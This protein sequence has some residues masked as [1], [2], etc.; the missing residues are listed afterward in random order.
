MGTRE[1]EPMLDMFLHEAFQ[2]VTQLELTLLETEQSG[3]LSNEQVNLIFRIMHTMKG[4]SS[5]MQYT[6][7]MELTHHAEDLF[8]HLRQTQPP[9]DMAK[10]TDLVLHVADAIRGE[11]EIIDRG[12]APYG[13]FPE[14]IHEVENYLK[15]LKGGP[16][17]DSPDAVPESCT[18]EVKL[19]FSEDCGMENVRCFT[20][21]QQLKEFSEVHYHEPSRLTEDHERCSELIRN[22]S[23]IVRFTTA[24]PYEHLMEFFSGSSYIRLVDLYECKPEDGKE[25]QD[26]SEMQLPEEQPAAPIVEMAAKQRKAEAQTKQNFISVNVE[27]MDKLMDMVGELVISEAMVTEHPELSGLHLEQFHKAARQ[28]RKITGELQDIVMSIRMVPLSATFQKMNRIVRDMSRK[29]DKEIHLSITGEE[30]EVDKGIIEQLSD[31]L[32][33]MIR[34]SI[35]HGIES[36]EERLGSGKPA[37]GNVSLEA[38]NAGN[39]VWITI[40]D[41]GRGLNRQRI[42]EK[43]RAAGLLHKEESEYTDREVYSM[44][45][46]PGLSTKE[47]VTEFSGRGVGMDAA[48]QNIQTLGGSIHVESFP[49]KESAF[50]IKIP[51]TLAIID[52]MTIKVGE[53]RFTIPTGAIRESFRVSDPEVIR[54]PEGHEMILIRGECYRIVKLHEC[55]RLSTRVTEFHQGI[56]LMIE[57][58]AEALCLFA[59]ELVGKQQVVVKSLPAIL[60][61]IRGVSGC[62]LLGDGS[63]SLIMDIPGVME[64]IAG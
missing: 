19:K 2:L 47:A 23:F 37:E 28:L 25:R 6:G 51:L 18:Y 45:F 59:D 44:I 20:I 8:H 29:L 21:L 13:A 57:H 52:G 46:L 10:L 49:G 32:M 9:E 7:I 24:Q 61:K 30:T 39:E 27:K 60:K 22:G 17:A 1:R 38:K 50:I 34:N 56:M 5:M 11:L 15:L 12:E 55:Y 53:S 43:A 54:D 14:L 42:L 40:R 58:D 62:T 16:Q 26:G 63:I 35:D 31:P 48:I 64:H 4:S 36:R 3:T 41:D 33:H